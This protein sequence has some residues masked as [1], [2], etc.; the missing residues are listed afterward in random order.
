MVPL[1]KPP[2]WRPGLALLH[3]DVDEA[4]VVDTVVDG[5]LVVDG[6]F[7]VTCEIEDCAVPAT[8]YTVGVSVSVFGQ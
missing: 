3:A 4:A 6:R 5:T 1:S 8:K 2:F 7:E